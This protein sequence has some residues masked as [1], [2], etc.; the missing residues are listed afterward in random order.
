[1]D[2]RVAPVV[3]RLADDGV[4]DA[5]GHERA[6]GEPEANRR[7]LA[8]AGERRRKRPGAD[9]GWLAL[10]DVEALGSL[11]PARLAGSGA[12]LAEQGDD[13]VMVVDRGIVHG[14]SRG[15]S[16]RCRTAAGAPPRR[17]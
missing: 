13:V 7:L 5:E 8:P 6:L 14:A 11:A 12:E 16:T 2:K 17:R 3:E 9:H 4:P 10:V 15:T 1:P